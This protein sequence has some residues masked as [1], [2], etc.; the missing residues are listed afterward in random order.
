[1]AIECEDQELLEGFLTESTELLEKLDDDLVTLEKSPS[2]AD[3]LNGIFRSIHTVKGAS[4]FL[5]FDLLVKV[6]HK[7]EDVLNRLRKGELF[8]NPEIMDVILEAVDLVKLLVNDIKGGE[9]QERETDATIEKL[10]PYLSENITAPTTLSGE[11][12]KAASPPPA[13]NDEIAKTASKEAASCNEPQPEDLAEETSAV[14]LIKA[15]AP[16]PPK[17]TA[18]K[19]DELADN[20]T[21]RVDVKRLDDLMNQVGELVLERNRMVQLHSDFQDGLDPAGFTDEFGK[22]SKRLNFVTSE[23]QMQ[24]LKMRM[25]PVEKVFKKFPRI[26]RNLARELGKEV[27]LQIFGEETELD[28]SVVDEIGDPLIHLIRN[29][30]DHGLEIP[31]ERLAA[32]KPKKGT[33]I[34]SATHEGNHIVISIKDNGRGINPDKV[35]AKA[36]EKGLITEEQLAAM[37]GRDILDLIFLPGFSTKEKATDLSGRGVGMDVVRTNI[38]KLNGIIEIKNEIGQGSEFIL[39]LPLTLAIIQSLLVEVESEIYSIP[40]SAVIETLKVEKSTFHLIG[41]REVLKLRESVLPL[42][43]LQKLFGCVDES[44]GKN[45]C[46]VVVVGVAEKRVGLVVTRLLGQ[47]EVAIKSLGKF[48]ANLPGIA[49]STILGDGRVALIVDPLAFVEGGEN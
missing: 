46:Y 15:K 47:Q 12:V 39:K 26:V 27:D 18:A 44:Q 9:I 28:R 13:K 34:L 43:R 11:S 21:V 3:L 6:T 32:G 20:S 31:E 1:M 42:I 4:S 14:A 10:L 24:V 25:I 2:D 38:K 35:A 23:L 29:A 5:G 17:A 22:L 33:V 8:V 16:I 48:L 41:G 45:S 49:G 19:G 7:T 37:G 40:L 30:L 36:I